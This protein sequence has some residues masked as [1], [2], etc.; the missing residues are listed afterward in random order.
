MSTDADVPDAPEIDPADRDDVLQLLEDA[1]QEAHRKIDTGRVYD[2]ENE[3]VRQKWIRTLAYTANVYRQTLKDRELEEM[4][5]RLDDL[6]GR[7]N[8]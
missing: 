8:G 5:D 1:I 4:R 2:A 7:I 6:E 3:R